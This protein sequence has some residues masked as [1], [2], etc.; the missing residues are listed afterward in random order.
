MGNELMV[1]EKMGDPLQAVE[2]IGAMIEKSQMF[3]CGIGQGQ[4]IA[5]TCYMEGINILEFKKKYH[6]IQ[7]SLTMRADA[8]LAELRK[9]G[10]NYRWIKTGDD[11]KEAEIEIE[12]KGMKGIA[13]FTLEDAKKAGIVKPNSGW[14]KYPDAMLRARAVSK[15]M[16]M[17]APEIITGIY[18]PEEVEDFTPDV[19]EVAEKA[20]SLF[21]K[22]VLEDVTP[23]PK[24]VEVPKVVDAVI[25]E[26]SKLEPEV[27]PEPTKPEPTK[28]ESIKE[29][30]TPV[31]PEIKKQFKEVFAGKE[32]KLKMFL[33]SAKVLKPRD[34]LDDLTIPQIKSILDKKDKYLK[35][36]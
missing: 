8:M 9:N 4:I 35:V 11:E 17:Y 18:T 36:L 22:V 31:I 14:F 3:G 33:V 20:N 6:I 19:K 2:K 5:L 26:E 25:I 21:K 10:G 23:K 16:R 30:E 34:K 29:P 12:Y 1:Y 27:K 7:N 13:K 15:A 24:T 32:E 28:P